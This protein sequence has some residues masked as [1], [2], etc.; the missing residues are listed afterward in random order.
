MYPEKKFEWSL[1]ALGWLHF[2]SPKNARLQRNSQRSGGTE[3]SSTREG[4][5]LGPE[6]W[7]TDRIASQPTTPPL[8]NPAE[9]KYSKSENVRIF[10]HVKNA[11][12]GEKNEKAAGEE[13]LPIFAEQLA[14][15]CLFVQ[16]NGEER[17]RGG[18][19]RAGAR[20]PLVE[21]VTST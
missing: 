3:L 15:V 20:E 2:I 4:A 9:K 16:R 14:V 10:T 7:E 1:C 5:G 18:V 17:V 19:R 11:L 12:F 21:C 6:N 8:S 13:H